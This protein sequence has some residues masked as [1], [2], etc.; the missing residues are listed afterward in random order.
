MPRKAK[1]L[2][3][4]R[5]GR[6]TALGPTTKRA[7]GKVVWECRCDC[8][9]I[10]YVN[11]RDLIRGNTRSCGC[12]MIEV[13]RR[14]GR[15]RIGSNNPNWKG[16]RKINKD[17]YVLIYF[18]EHPAAQGKGYVLE[19]RL[20]IEEKLG[21]PLRPEEQVHHIDGNPANNAPE[22]LIVFANAGRHR[23]YHRKLDLIAEET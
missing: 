18:P 22:N 8:G 21:R 9:N 20:V 11:S 3:G 7:S 10:T 2:T 19:H 23:A 6:L 16:G 12:L 4:Q 13:N 1:D 15:L 14:K 17:G 5:F